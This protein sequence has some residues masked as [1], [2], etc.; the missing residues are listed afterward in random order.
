MPPPPPKEDDNLLFGITVPAERGR[1]RNLIAADDREL[2][3]GFSAR[4]AGVE[5]NGGSCRLG[6]RAG[7]LARG[8]VEP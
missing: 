5:R 4:V 6:K 7:D 2:F 8:G 1:E 3:G